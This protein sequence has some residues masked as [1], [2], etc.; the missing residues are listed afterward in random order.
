MAE[1]HLALEILDPP[2]STAAQT[3]TVYAQSMASNCLDTNVK[4]CSMRTSHLCS[5]DS[6]ELRIPGVTLL[7]LP[8]SVHGRL[9]DPGQRCVRGVRRHEQ[10]VVRQHRL[11]VQRLRQDRQQRRWITVLQSIRQSPLMH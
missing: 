8:R 7:L 4:G 6:D 3:A 9:A 11:P 5:S 1:K 10:R 2:M